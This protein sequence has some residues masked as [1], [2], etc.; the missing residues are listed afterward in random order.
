MSVSSAYTKERAGSAFFVEIL[1][2]KI[3]FFQD[4]VV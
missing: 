2:F 4:D 1:C 3:F